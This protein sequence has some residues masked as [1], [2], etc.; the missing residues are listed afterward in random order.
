MDSYK[1]FV[2]WN[3]VKEQCKFYIYSIAHTINTNAT[4]NI[5]YI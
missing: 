1:Y 2:I 3:V 5:I 4:Y